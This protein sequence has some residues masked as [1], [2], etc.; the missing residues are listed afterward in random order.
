MADEH[1]PASPEEQAAWHRATMRKRKAWL[2]LFVLV[3]AGIGVM[4]VVLERRGQP[5]NPLLILPLVGLVAGL[6]AALG[7]AVC[8]ACGE[9][10]FKIPLRLFY[11]SSC[12]HC[13]YRGDNS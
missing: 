7:N 1:A 8:P 6:G 10:F 13:G 12:G 9:S 2:A 4:M 11:G 5:P 3:I